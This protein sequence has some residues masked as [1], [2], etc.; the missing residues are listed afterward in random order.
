MF[1]SSDVGDI[2]G[3]K[4]WFDEIIDHLKRANGCLAIMTP[5]SIHFS[6]HLCWIF[7]IGT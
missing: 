5:R 6:A 1:C 2:E 4:K 7:S 3:G